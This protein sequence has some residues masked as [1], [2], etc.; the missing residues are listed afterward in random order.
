[1]PCHKNCEDNAS[2]VAEI[3]ALLELIAVLERKGQHVSEG[4]I[5]IGF[6]YKK[7]HKKIMK[8]ILKCNVCAEEAGAEMPMIKVT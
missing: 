4:E 5:R 8:S 6:D 2:G 1:M 3:I 7:G